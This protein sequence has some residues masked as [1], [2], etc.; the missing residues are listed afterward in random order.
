MVSWNDKAPERVHH[1]VQL[2]PHGLP[3][4]V[5]YVRADLAGTL[6]EEME[7]AGFD[8][9]DEYERWKAQHKLPRPSLIAHIWDRMIST[10]AEKAKSVRHRSCQERV[11]KP[12]HSAPEADDFSHDFEDHD[13][14]EDVCV[15][16]YIDDE[17]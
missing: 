3:T 7:Q 10:A 15:C 9:I 13:C 12:P 11:K 16:A 6:T 17:D 4:Y 1:P 2:H 5:E 14:G 8:A